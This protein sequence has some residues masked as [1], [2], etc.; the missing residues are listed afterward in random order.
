MKHIFIMNPAAGSGEAAGALLSRVRTWAAGAGIEY[1]IHRSLGKQE[2]C[3][4]VSKK[5]ATGEEICFYACGGD[6]TVNDVLCGLIGYDNARLGVI[7]CGSGNDF[8][9]NFSSPESFFDL[10][11]QLAAEY[12]P[13]DV[14][15][16]GDDGYA[17]NMINIG[18]DCD[19]VTRV[20]ELKSRG[21]NSRKAYLQGVFEVLPHR[22][23]Y[24][25]RFE[26]DG[27]VFEEDALLAAIANGMFC[28]GGFKSSPKA[29]VNDGLMDVG[30]IRPLKGL[31]LVSMLIKYH[32]GTHLQDREAD[33]Y[34]A[35]FQ[36][37]SF[38][39][40]PLDEPDAAVDGEVIKFR[41]TRF[42]ILP[43]AVRVAVPK[44]SGLVKGAACEAAEM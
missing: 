4:Y 29:R 18:V 2:I 9:R 28:G 23:T 25:M 11:A 38:T 22:K 42:E 35:Y 26:R 40:T 31:K 30:I 36:C 6:G 17:I 13:V 7:P 16:C 24:R 41:E 34:V 33:K 8:V 3:D 44:G 5:A 20:N 43:G 12:V 32:Q 37:S 14:I 21:S 10:D 27:E 19:V 39:L 15:K 1:E